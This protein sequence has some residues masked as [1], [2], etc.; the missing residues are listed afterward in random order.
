MN[1]SDE[2]FLIVFAL[3][4]LIFFIVLISEYFKKKN[5][6]RDFLKWLENNDFNL[7]QK[8]QNRKNKILEM[9]DRMALM[10]AKMLFVSES[11]K[12]K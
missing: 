10:A 12:G 5:Q 7:Y 1:N 11:K 9:N 6:N 3:G 4:L 8:Y 2:K